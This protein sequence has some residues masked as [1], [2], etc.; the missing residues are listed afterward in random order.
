MIIR[1][2]FYK[3]PKGD[4]FSHVISRWTGLFNWGVTGYSHVELGFNIDGEWKWYSSASRNW[5]GTTGTRWIDNERLF[6]H[7]ERWDVFD[8]VPSLRQEFM[9]ATCEAEKGKDY[10]WFG[11]LGFVT[12]FGQFNQKNKWYCS[13]ICHYVFFGKWKKRISPERLFTEMKPSFVK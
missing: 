11:I 2:A 4:F 8:V 3:P 9:I 6:K 5:D 10:D 7:P 1:V 12:I 13:E